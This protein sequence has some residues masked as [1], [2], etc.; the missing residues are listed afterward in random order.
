MRIKNIRTHLKGWRL[1]RFIE[2]RRYYLLLKRRKRHRRFNH[3]QTKVPYFKYLPEDSRFLTVV[4]KARYGIKVGNTYVTCPKG[5]LIVKLPRI[6]DFDK[7]YSAS[8]QVIDIF[9]RALQSGR[10]ISYIDFEEV[11]EVSPACMMAFSAY[12]DMWKMYAPN[13]KTK[14]QTWHPEIA[15]RF[16][17]IGFFKM[18][19]FPE[20][21]NK[22]ENGPVKFMP[23]QSKSVCYGKNVDVG[24]DSVCLQKDIEEFIGR[25]LKD[26]RMYD[27]VSEAVRNIW[28]HAYKGIKSSRLPFK[29]WVSVAYD[30][31]LNE[32]RIIVFDHGLGIPTTIKTSN[33]FS[34]YQR[35]INNWSEGERLYLAFERERRKINKRAR[36]L[37]VGRGHGCPDIARLVSA[38]D[39][40]MVRDGSSLTVISGRARYRLNGGTM[41]GRGV[42]EDLPKKLQGTMIEWRIRL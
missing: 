6:F 17:E 8:V 27:S 16:S 5:S 1:R 12:A 9:R 10:R 36:S 7:N 23:I 31:T 21:V 29:W 2:R 37:I 15:R 24:Y 22:S 3:T 32:L 25:S 33:T 26:V 20:P 28:D 34:L 13:V 38:K 41:Q 40:N 30:D 4:S 11:E 19:G 14:T 39:E 42:K 35:I 18:L